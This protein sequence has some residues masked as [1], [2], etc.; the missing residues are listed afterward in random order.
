M[1]AVKPLVD[2]RRAPPRPLQ[3]FSDTIAEHPKWPLKIEAC[4]CLQQ[5][6]FTEEWLAENEEGNRHRIV[7][8]QKPTSFDDVRKLNWWQQRL[9]TEESTALSRASC[10]VARRAELLRNLRCSDEEGLDNPVSRATSRRRRTTSMRI[11]P[12]RRVRRGSTFVNLAGEE[13]EF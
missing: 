11:S 9:L 13:S 4:K 7:P 2:V 6:M 12:D 1:I 10:G 5:W 8:V 3:E